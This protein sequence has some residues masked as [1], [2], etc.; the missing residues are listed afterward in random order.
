MKFLVI[1]TITLFSVQLSYQASDGHGGYKSDSEEVE[2]EGNA[3]KVDESSLISRSN[4]TAEII[5]TIIVTEGP[6]TRTITTPKP[7]EYYH[8]RV[9]HPQRSRPSWNFNPNIHQQGS[10][11]FG[12]FRVSQ[13]NIHRP[14]NVNSNIS[15]F[16]I[17]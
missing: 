9:N 7:C 5:E 13:E 3:T 10:R 8:Q 12:P 4:A 16:L 6:T 17:K 1:I 14:I 11:S 2:E 15:E